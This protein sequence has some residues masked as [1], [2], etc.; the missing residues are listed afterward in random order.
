MLIGRFDGKISA[1]YQVAFP[2]KF[3]EI[4]GDKLIITKGFEQALMVIAEQ[5]WEQVLEDIET[6]SV[7]QGIARETKR[8]LLG[9]A[10]FVDLDQKGRFIL[11]DYLRTFGELQED[12]VFIGQERY[13]EIWDKKRWDDYN[14]ELAGK[15]ESIV[16]RLTKDPAQKDSKHD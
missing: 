1:K 12:I 10:A 13:V 8:F 11:P 7:T 4:L 3:R 9:G 16:E 2:K 14:L 15:I 5:N 6:T